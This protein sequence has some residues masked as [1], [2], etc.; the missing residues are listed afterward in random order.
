MK[1]C[2]GCHQLFEAQDWRCP[3]CG[4][5]PT[6]RDGFIAFAPELADDNAHYPP[7]FFPTL[8][9]LEAGNFWFQARNRLLI[10]AFGRYFPTA[11][12]FLEIGCGTGFVLE[13]IREAFPHLAIAGSEIYTSGLQFARQRLNTVELVQLDARTLPYHDEFDVIGAF[14]VLEH[15]EADDAVLRQMAR[16]VRPGG[17]I[18]LTVPQHMALWSAAD[19]LARHVRRYSARELTSKVAEAGF[20]V[21]RATSFVSLLLPLVYGSR[22][23]PQTQGENRVFE[24]LSISGLPNSLL[25]AAMTLEHW[26]IRHGVSFPLGSSLLVVARKL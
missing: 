4:V 3:R 21:V 16:A 8:A 24:E 10:W 1:I 19:D 17:G 7:D 9:G 14:D 15:I 18:L 6:R 2:P 13:G 5:E 12:S 11:R 26:F 25:G 23:M 22:R 20:D